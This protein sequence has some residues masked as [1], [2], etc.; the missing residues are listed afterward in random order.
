MKERK[1]L[2]GKTPAMILFEGRSLLT[3][4]PEN[5]TYEEYR[6]M[7]KYQTKVLKLVLSKS[8]NP[9]ILRSMGVKLNYNYHPRVY[10]IQPDDKKE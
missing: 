1:A 6:F 3:K 7:R 2:K 9:N 8:S 5:M 10:N 4:R